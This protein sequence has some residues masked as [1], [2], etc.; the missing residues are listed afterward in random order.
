[1]L[2]KDLQK[3]SLTWEEAEYWQL[4]TDKSGVKEWP[5]VFTWMWDESKVQDQ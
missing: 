5:S 3:M 4:S 2:N 1:M